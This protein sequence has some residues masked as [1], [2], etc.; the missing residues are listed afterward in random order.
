MKL[1]DRTWPE[2]KE[3]LAKG[4]VAILPV[5]SCEAHGPHLALSTDVV[6]A[7]EAAR[8][9]AAKLRT[10]G[11]EALVLPPVGY[12]VTD[13][14]AGFAGTITLPAPAVTA[15]V[16]SVCEAALRA[17]FR[18]VV[19]ANAHLEP[20]HIAAVRAAVEGLAH[21]TFP[22]KTRRPWSQALGD[23]FKSGACHA[24]RY[25]TSLVQAAAPPLVR[26]SLRATLPENPIS[27]G[28]AIKDGKKTFEEA[29]GAD[30]YFGAPAEATADE[31]HRLYDTL[32]EMIASAAKEA[33][34]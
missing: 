5:G 9:A 8:R 17:G 21:V 25:E 32:A 7:E 24:G 15:L 28:R 30:A 34:A 14:A 19:V 11:I 23:E 27:I 33:L 4:A 31:G 13:F 12:G 26:E 10:E 18:A 2:A 1:G 16:R 3:A 20:A 6:I 29:G 22:D